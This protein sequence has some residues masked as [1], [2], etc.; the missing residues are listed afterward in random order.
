VKVS[1]LAPGEIHFSV[2]LKW[3]SSRSMPTPYPGASLGF[4]PPG[5]ADFKHSCEFSEGLSITTLVTRH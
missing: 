1:I 3:S 5:G 4:A 2:P